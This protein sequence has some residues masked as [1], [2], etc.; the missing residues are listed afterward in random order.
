MLILDEVQQY[1]GESTDRAVHVTEMAE[2][3]QTQ[4]DSRVLLVASGQ[5]ALSGTTAAA[6]AADRF[7]INV[8]L[9]DTDV[10]AVTRK[11][12]LHKKASAVEPVRRALERKRRRGQSA[13]AGH[14]PRGAPE[15][16]EIASRTTRCCRRGAASGRSASARWTP[17]A[18]TA[19]CVRSCASSTTRSAGRR[20]PRPR[21]RDPRG[22]ALRCDCPRPRELRRVL[23]NELATRI[24]QLDDRTDRGAAEAHLLAGLPGQQAAAR[25]RAS[26]SACARTHASDRGPARR[27][28]SPA[29]SGPLPPARSRRAR[30]MASTKAR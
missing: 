3:V 8:Q 16:R 10:E 23:L 25:S 4:L 22:R 18:R 19:S 27:S 29:D 11:V 14:A 13:A 7:R 9:S 5:S 6:E 17:P 1:I 20:R 21:R 26:T 15:D 30:A 28:S 12:L 24:A 2:A